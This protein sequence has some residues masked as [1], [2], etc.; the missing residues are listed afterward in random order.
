MDDEPLC[1][2]LD[3]TECGCRLRHIRRS[4]LPWSSL[5]SLKRMKVGGATVFVNYN[6]NIVVIFA[7]LIFHGIICNVGRPPPFNLSSM[8]HLILLAAL[9]ALLLGLVSCGGGQQSA[10]EHRA[11]ATRN[12]QLS[13]SVAV[14]YESLV[15]E[16]Y[17]GYFGRPADSGGLANYTA[18]L[19][20]ANAPTTV[21]G[22]LDVYAT[23]S[24]VKALLD[25]F[26]A[27]DESQQLYPVCA[28]I[29]CDA[30]WISALYQGLFSREPDDAGEQF[31]SN[32]LNSQGATRAAVL[33]SVLAGAQGSDAGLLARKVNIAVQ[34]TRA[35]DAAGLDYAYNGQ[36]AAAIAREMMQNAP[37]FTD[38]AAVQANIDA[39]VQRLASQFSGT[40]DEATPLAHRILLLASAERFSDSGARLATLSSVMTADLNQLHHSGA[41]WSATVALAANSV[42]AIRAQLKGYDGV[43]LIGQIPFPSS[44]GMPFPDVYR[45]PE[46]PDFQI[47]STG[48]VLNGLAQH[49]ADPRC[50]SGLMVSILRGTTA[51]AEATEVAIKLDQMIAYHRSSATANASWMQSFRFIEAGWF[52]G[53][54]NQWGDLSASWYG[55]SLYA[56][57]AISYLNQGTSSQRRDAFL[58]CIGRNTEICGASLHGSPQYLDF[59]GQGVIGQFYSSETTYLYGSQIA[60]QSV[61]AKYIDLASCNTQDFLV[62]QSIGTSLLMRGNALLT[63]G[64]TVETLYANTY[65]DDVIKNEYTLLQNGST[66]AEAFYGRMEGTP[67]SI[68]GDPYITM[69]PAPTGPQPKLVI[70]GK[71]YGDTV[72]T[73]SLAMPDAVGGASSVRIVSFSNRGDADLHLRIGSMFAVTGVDYGTSQGGE[74]EYG[75]N[76]QYETDLKQIFSDGLVAI[77]PSFAIEQNGGAMPV[78][79]QPGRSVAIAYKLSVRTGA[80]G[81]PKRPGLYTGQLTITSDDPSSARIYLAVRGNVR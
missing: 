24:A 28:W 64:S 12:V 65:E 27:S 6:K 50:Q 10:Q 43:L 69:R 54:E 53:P 63:H 22:L 13:A 44:G 19:S 21:R 37:G 77:W 71:H 3:L 42:T 17:V 9:A 61:K 62:D 66:F 25:S 34:F 68:Q 7:A 51:Q 38:D 29:G 8:R 23:N 31:W 4:A 80:D 39:T 14:D 72:S 73:V 35:L 41:T 5:R 47:D 60:A 81:K 2:H 58:D 18:A 55:T 57:D 33:L 59:E 36:P 74:W 78:T 30:R 15:Q 48:V 67:L 11:M 56:A 70:D 46:C 26:A 16:L 79:L 20:I 1:R 49:S 76:A 45:L 32:A 52:G 40:V 75:D